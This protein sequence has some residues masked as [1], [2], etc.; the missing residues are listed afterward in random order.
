MFCWSRTF[1]HQLMKVIYRI[2]VTT[3][4]Y[5]HTHEIEFNII[6]NNSLQFS[7]IYTQQSDNYI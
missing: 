5:I 3:Y 7:D 1:P 6:L 2:K 4:I